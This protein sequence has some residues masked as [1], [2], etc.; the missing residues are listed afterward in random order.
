MLV[1]SKETLI[2]VGVLLAVGILGL[3]LVLTAPRSES[4]AAGPSAPSAPQT[5]VA[6]APAAPPTT[7]VP[8]ATAVQAPPPTAQ[9]PRTTVPTGSL[10][11]VAQPTE[12]PTA[13]PALPV[14]AAIDGVIYEGEYAHSTEAGG[15]QIHWSNDASFLRVGLISPGTGYLAIGF[16]PD[17]R[18][19]GANFVLAAVR[20]GQLWTRD[21]Y[22][23]G[24][25]THASDVSLGG[26][27]DILAAAGRESEGKTYVEFV[28]ALNSGDRF[29]KPFTPGTTYDIVISFHETSDDFDTYHSRRGAG[30]MRLDPG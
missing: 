2:I 25:V 6:T 13:S 9:A 12:T 21:D 3:V 27:D 4:V 1:I 29:D 10:V 15:F 19:Q 14:A 24:P 11:Q 26:T 8:A 22:G 16:D 28:I 17:N 30:K 7:Q 20:S 23:N 5:T 18:M